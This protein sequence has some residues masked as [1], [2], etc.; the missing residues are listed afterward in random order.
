M[1]YSDPAQPYTTAREELDELDDLDRDLS[2]RG[3]NLYTC[4]SRLIMA[5][6]AE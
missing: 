1:Y 6:P 4:G 3:V 5:I 2:V